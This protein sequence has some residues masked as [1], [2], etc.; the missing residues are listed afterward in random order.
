MFIIIFKNYKKKAITTLSCLI[1]FILLIFSV[2]YIVLNNISC[3]VEIDD[4][5]YFSYPLKLS[6][7][8][9]F[10]SR[11]VEEPTIK[12]GVFFNPPKNKDLVKYISKQGNFQFDYPSI[13]SLT[14]KNF[15]GSE[16]L[17]HIDL[18]HKSKNIRGLI[19]VWKIHYSLEK[20]LEESKATSLQNF[21]NFSSKPIIKDNSSGF[22][23]DY[24]IITD[25]GEGFKAMELFY[26]KNDKIYRIS[27]FVPEKMWSKEQYD[28]F[29]E[30]AGSFKV[31]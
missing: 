27:Y 8:N 18:Q 16:I 24:T 17:Y 29:W 21:K 1:F 9:V 28:I 6:I 12:A 14:E 7:S 2:H 11:Y 30:I 31:N 22:L 23:W 20:F 5:I 25:T 26:S 15:L 4:T 3:N 19:Q 10:V 13:F